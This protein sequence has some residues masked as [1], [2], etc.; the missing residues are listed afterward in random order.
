MSRPGVDANANEEDEEE[1]LDED[2]S[3]L[4]VEGLASRGDVEGLVELAKAHRTGTRGCPR[5]MG[6][7][8]AAYRAAGDL[9]HPESEYAAALFYLNGGAIPRD[10]KEGSL[11]L[12]SAAEKGSLDAKVVLGNLYELGVHYA[13]DPAKADVWYRNAARSAGIDLAPGTPEHARALAELGCARYAEA[14]ASDPSIAEDVKASLLRKARAR[15]AGLRD[16]ISSSPEGDLPPPSALSGSPDAKPP[17]PSV[18]V[19]SAADT[20]AAASAQVAVATALIAEVSDPKKAPTEKKAPRPSGPSPF[21]GKA[22]AGAF[23]YA[24]LFTAAALGAAF[25]AQAGARELV[26]HGTPLPLFGTKVA[27]VFPTVLA[28]LGVIPQLLV[29]R[30][31][32][33]LRAIVA[34]AAGFGLG[35][36]LHGTGKFMAMEPRSYQGIAFAGAAFLAALLAQGFVG[37]SKGSP[38]PRR[39]P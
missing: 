18:S 15:G 8:F 11:R 27:A 9:G 22:G 3:G 32:S 1:E 25:A 28:V 7:T 26:E 34:G 21:T 30:F 6:K 35:W 16:R 5:D 24:L 37:G 12:R 31:M 10:L 36:V 13:R 29:Y 4:T 38:E 2:L 33:V 20:V 17:A 23:L 19:D 14:L 39:R